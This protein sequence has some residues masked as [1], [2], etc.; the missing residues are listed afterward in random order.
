[1]I[2]QGMAQGTNDL[3]EQWTIDA[4]YIDNELDNFIRQR[5]YTTLSQNEVN[6]HL[7]D[8]A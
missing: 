1:M 3:I 5:M 7:R 8:C 2:K 4:K 6:K